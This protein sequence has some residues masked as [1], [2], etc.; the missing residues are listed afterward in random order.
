MEENDRN[1]SRRSFLERVGATGI[2][3]A[4]LGSSLGTATAAS[5]IDQFVP[6]S[7][8]NYTPDNRTAADIDWIVVHVAVGTYQGTIDL[9]RQPNRRSVSAHYVISNYSDT[10]G[11]P[12]AVTK[13]VD[14]TNRAHHARGS[15]AN[16]I[17]IEH[18]WHREYGRYIN[19]ACYRSSADLIESLADQYDIP[20]RYYDSH[21]C[22]WDDDV[23]GGII[24]HLHT[25]TSTACTGY[26]DV[27]RTCPYPDWDWSAFAQFLDGERSPAAGPLEPG[28][29]VVTE[30]TTNVRS[31]PSKAD[32]VVHTHPA[33]IEGT[34]TT[35]Q[36]GD[37]RVRRD[38]HTWWYVEYDHV[39]GYTAA[40]DLTVSDPADDDDD[41]D[42]D[43]GLFDM[44]WR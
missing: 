31:T 15:N 35:P 42:D 11:A 18:E 9:F 4:A 14:E 25:P 3:S 19:D 36:G 30:P 2:A 5:P 1:S 12:G 27:N 40:E 38:G 24:G 6:A 37:E 41:Q 10:A 17:G 16:S 33:G 32:N 43:I 22:T 28:T 44:L 21:T 26:N 23:E 34:I 13:M 8:S 20:L 7:A 29:T 39:D